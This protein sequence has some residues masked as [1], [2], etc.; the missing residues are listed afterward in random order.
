MPRIIRL[1]KEYSLVRTIVIA[2][3][4][5]HILKSG[6]L[7]DIIETIAVTFGFINICSSAM[8]RVPF[9]LLYHGNYKRHYLAA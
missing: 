4:N 1:H 2:I 8:F 5:I 9:T 6:S 3:N 7:I